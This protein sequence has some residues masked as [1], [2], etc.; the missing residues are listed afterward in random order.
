M[1]GKSTS[2]RGIY[3]AKALI[4]KAV[5]YVG[6]VNK[7]CT[8]HDIVSFV[9][10]MN[11]N[12]VSCFEV[13]PRR[14]YVDDRCDDRKAFRLCISDDSSERMLDASLWPQSVIVSNWHFKQRSTEAGAD[15]KRRRVEDEGASAAEEQSAGHDQ[16]T[17]YVSTVDRDSGSA[18]N[19]TLSDDTI[20]AVND[21]VSAVDMDDE[22][23]APCNNG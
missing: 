21:H 17:D 9:K 23:S 13:R 11:V 15:D 5:F 16:S 3:A 8:E 1:F 10:G 12:V 2:R 14:R 7:E 6:N 19:N 22:T 18:Q 20:L 4:R